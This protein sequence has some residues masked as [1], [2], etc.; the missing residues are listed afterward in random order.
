MLM[1]TQNATYSYLI[2]SMYVYIHVCMCDVHIYN[3]T[4]VTYIVLPYIILYYIFYYCTT[5]Q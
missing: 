1:G 5:Y 3:I 4:Y 2:P